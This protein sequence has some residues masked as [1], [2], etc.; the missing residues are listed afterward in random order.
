MF[1]RQFWKKC[2]CD[3]R[4]IVNIKKAIGLLSLFGANIWR[5]LVTKSA[6][7]FLLFLVLS[8]QKVVFHHP[9]EFWLSVL[10]PVSRLTLNLILYT[11]QTIRQVDHPCPAS[12]LLAVSKLKQ[13]LS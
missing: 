5:K 12:I 2:S 13:S 3:E 6:P 4:Q 1:S 8:L 9:D 7:T 11:V 10:L